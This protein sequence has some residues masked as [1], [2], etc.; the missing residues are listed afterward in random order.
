MRAVAAS[1]ILAAVAWMLATID[2]R[3]TPEQPITLMIVTEPGSIV[4]V[5]RALRDPEGRDPEWPDPEWFDP[6]DPD[7][8]IHPLV[9]FASDGSSV[10]RHLPPGS[11]QI[12]ARVQ[13]STRELVRLV[14]L[15]RDRVQRIALRPTATVSI[16]G[17]VD[18][19]SP[20]FRRG[21]KVGLRPPFRQSNTFDIAASPSAPRVAVA[22]DGRFRFDRVAVIAGESL[23]PFV[24]F[25]SSVSETGG[26]S[27][28]YEPFEFDEPIRVPRGLLDDPI[29]LS[30][31]WVK[32]P[33]VTIACGLVFVPIDT[34]S[35]VVDLSPSAI[36][37]G[38]AAS[39]IEVEP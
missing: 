20:D 32:C 19:R 2:P 27:R 18:P 39:G 9:S 30:T 38:R 37:G 24:E 5:S 15:E 36:E 17:R 12:T 31:A 10:V 8:E 22:D 25:P 3:T 35:P 21:L 23:I 29:R 11:Y 13:D 14:E 33:S 1:M 28:L 6:K 4:S 16:E 26:S 7:Y 34:T